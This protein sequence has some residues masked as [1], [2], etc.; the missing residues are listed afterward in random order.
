MVSEGHWT[1][2]LPERAGAARHRRH[3]AAELRRLAAGLARPHA[4]ARPPAAP[5]QRRRRGRRRARAHVPVDLRLLGAAQRVL[6]RTVPVSRI[7]GGI[8]MGLVAIP[9]AYRCGPV[10]TDPRRRG[11]G[12]RRRC[13]VRARRPRTRRTTCASCVRRPT[14]PPRGRRARQRPRAGA[15]RGGAHRAVP[16]ARCSRREGLRDLEVLVLD[17]GSTD[18]TADVVRRAAGR[19]PAACSVVDGGGDAAAR[20]L[21]RQ[22]VG[23]PPARARG[24]RLGA[25][26]RR[27]RRRRRTARGRR[28]ASRCCATTGLDLVSPYPR[29]LADGALPRLVQPLL[30][31]SWA[32]LLP[33]GLAETS[34]RESL[35]AA[36]GQLLAVD[37]A[38][39]RAR[40]AATRRCAA[41]CSTTSRCCARSS[42][43]GGRG[44]VVD[45]TARRDVPHVRRRAARSSRATRSRCGRRSGRRPGAAAV[46]GLLV[47]ALRRARRSPPSPARRAAR[48]GW[49]RSGYA[50]G[51]AGRVLV[52]RR[53]GRPRRSTRVAHPVVGRRCSARWSRESWRR[54]APAP[55]PG[56]AARSPEHRG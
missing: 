37:A 10:A 14:H 5:P 42:A 30:Q 40:A 34:P 36:N 3:P 9:Y 41:R 53:T 56:A 1:W 12:R 8:V 38:R 31:W 55:S 54:H 52:A 29:Q 16:R 26:L 2:T 46:V 28:H 43:S 45:G 21:A 33:L 24:D 35:V 48:A 7:W 25:R 27:R 32:T 22:D 44:V 11:A 17:D 4:A 15:R 19:R 13:S 47:A 51:V 49:A 18:G 20:R 50:A 39:L 23:L 6:R